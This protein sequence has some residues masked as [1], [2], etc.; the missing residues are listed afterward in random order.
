M[1][2]VISDCSPFNNH[3]QG[4]KEEA[5]AREIY[6]LENHD[7]DLSHPTLT[8]CNFGMVLP[9]QHIVVS[10]RAHREISIFWALNQV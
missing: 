5:W 3:K 10:K 9:M 6:F 2:S 7:M 1:F 8:A 4:A